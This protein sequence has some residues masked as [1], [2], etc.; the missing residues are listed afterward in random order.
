MLRRLV[1]I[2][3][4]AICLDGIIS[5]QSAEAQ[6]PNVQREFYEG[7][8]R[9]EGDRVTFCISGRS[10]I[11]GVEKGIGRELAAILLLDVDFFVLSATSRFTEE[12]FY[13]QL[14]ILLHDEC[15]AFM[16]VNLAA[17]FLPDWLT[18]TQAYLRAPYVLAHLDTYKGLNDIPRDRFVGSQAFSRADHYFIAYLQNL[19]VERRWRRLPYDSVDMMV[20][21]LLEQRIAAGIVWAPALYAVTHGDPTS[22]GIEVSS[23]TPLPDIEASVGMVLQARDVFLRDQLDAAI[24]ELVREQIIDD[25]LRRKGI[26]VGSGWYP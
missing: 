20:R 5:V 17:D 24:S 19:P 10:H 26:R 22:K 12:S 9:L 1:P 14:F 2:L 3:I 4:V 16:G 18:V 7:R 6:L 15:D 8:R 25:I 23:L 21:H 13:E 11:L